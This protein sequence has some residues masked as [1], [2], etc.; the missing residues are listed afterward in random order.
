MAGSNGY[1]GEH[2]RADQPSFCGCAAAGLV[3][4]CPRSGHTKGYAVGYSKRSSH[5]RSVAP[6]AEI[7][8]ER[9]ASIKVELL[10]DGD[11]YTTRLSMVL[12]PRE[13]KPTRPIYAI[14]GKE[15]ALELLVA[16]KRVC[17]ICD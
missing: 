6:I 17:T 13:G 1:A 12:P 2:A 4:L 15:A 14:F 3:V 9:G 10:C 7:R 8:L 16:L 5:N 11:R